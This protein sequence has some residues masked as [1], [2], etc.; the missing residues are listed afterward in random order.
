MVSLPEE[1]EVVAG[2]RSPENKDFTM[3]EFLKISYIV[4]SQCASQLEGEQSYIS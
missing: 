4:S 1:V 3:F 2:L